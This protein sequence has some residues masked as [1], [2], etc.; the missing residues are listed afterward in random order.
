MLPVCP[1]IAGCQQQAVCPDGNPVLR[2]G[3]PDI[4]KGCFGSGIV[5][6]YRPGFAAIVGMQ[7]DGVMT[8]RPADIE[9]HKI[10]AGQRGT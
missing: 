6:L 3:K 1:G 5:V 8:D 2:I 9:R 4:E 7:N 10:D